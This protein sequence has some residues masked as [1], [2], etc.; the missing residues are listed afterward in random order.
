VKEREVH[1]PARRLGGKIMI[2]MIIQWIKQAELNFVTTSQLTFVVYG[3]LLNEYCSYFELQENS[4][5][6]FTELFL[7]LFGTLQS[8]KGKFL[9]ARD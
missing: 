9:G 2:I 6:I 5:L 8:K 3:T 1:Q 7:L 4:T